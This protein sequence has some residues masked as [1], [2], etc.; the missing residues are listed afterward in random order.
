MRRLLTVALAAVLVGS[1]QPSKQEDIVVFRTTTRLVEFTVVALDKQGRAVKDLKKEDLELTE[2]GKRRPIAFFRFEGAEDAARKPQPLPPQTFSNRVE[3]APGPARNISAI[4]LDTLNTQPDQMMWAKSQ[5]VRYLKT[6]APQTRVAVFHLGAQLTVLHDFTDDPD[7]LRARIEKGAL[8][9]PLQAEEDIGRMARE[10]EALLNMFPDVPGLEEMLRNQ[11]EIEAMGNVQVRRRRTEQT[12]LSLEALGAHLAGI[13]GRKN[14]IWIGGGVTM[15]AITGAMGFGP[16][17]G[18]QSWEEMVSRSAR[19]LAQ[20]GVALYVV[21]AKGLVGLQNVTA[22]VA[23]PPP[24]PGRGRFEKQE[25]AEQLSSD[26]VPAANELAAITGGRVIRNTN[27]MA[28]GMRLAAE[29]V[30]GSYTLGFYTEGEPDGKWHALKV[31]AAR[32]GVRLM[33]R[34]GFQAA[35]AVP[36]PVEWAAEEWKK[37]LRDPLG[38]SAIGLDAHCRKAEGVEAGSV[39]FAMQMDPGS[40][41][42]LREGERVVTEIEIGLGDMTATGSAAFHCEKGRIAFDA[43]RQK[44]LSPADLRYTRVWKPATGTTHIRVIVHDKVA[45]TYGTLDVPLPKQ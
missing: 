26:T 25:Q 21:D 41:K 34:Q 8:Q 35:D 30:K 39:F 22:S 43:S 23:Q 28:D 24:I 7:S 37:A 29:D 14:L 45:G 17:G 5:V 16:H 19:R 9:L 31:K 2:K 18:F 15:L 6:L 38:S 33:Y 1:A 4:V 10:A 32:P 27:D 11:I 20:A 13:P 12:L 40:L 44:P 42:F 3:Y 36:A